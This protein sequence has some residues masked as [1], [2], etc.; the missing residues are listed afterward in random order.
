MIAILGV[1]REDLSITKKMEPSSPQRE[2]GLLYTA[3]ALE[4]A[5]VI[6]QVSQVS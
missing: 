5:D 3:S 6:S 2:H 1:K 4:Q